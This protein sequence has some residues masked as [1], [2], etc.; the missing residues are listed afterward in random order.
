[1]YIVIEKGIVGSY[2]I[3]KYIVMKLL[4]LEAKACKCQWIDNYLY[5]GIRYINIL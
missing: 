4:C 2:K 3:S 5:Y 1:M